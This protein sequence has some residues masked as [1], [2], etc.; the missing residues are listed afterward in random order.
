M[1]LAWITY[2]DLWTMLKKWQISPTDY[3]TMVW[4]MQTLWANHLSDW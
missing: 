1:A 4:Y 2:N 3:S